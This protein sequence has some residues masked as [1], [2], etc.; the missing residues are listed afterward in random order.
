MHIGIDISVLRAAKGPLLR[1]HQNLIESLVSEGLVHE[2]TLVD[3]L[4]FNEGRAMPVRLRAFDEED[5]RVV[6]VTG[7][8][9]NTI[10]EYFG[11]SE[12]RRYDLANAVDR[13]LDEPWSSA[14]QANIDA[15]LRAVLDDVDVFHGSDLLW[16]KSP[17]G[18]AALTYFD[19]AHLALP[20]L[21]GDARPALIE[22]DAFAQHTAD[23]IIALSESTR[24]ALMTELKIPSER[25]SVVYGAAAAMFRPH[26]PEERAAA[27][28][29]YGLTDESYLLCSTVIEPRA[30][31]ERLAIAHQQLRANDAD[32]P[33][34]LIAGPRGYEHEAV[35]EAIEG[36]D[37]H[38]RVLD[39]LSDQELAA[40]LSGARG[41]V[42]PVFADGA[43]LIALEALACGAP[44]LVADVG[45]LPEIVG[46]AGLYC[47][48]K[49]AASISAGLAAL[50][51][52][53]RSGDLRVAGPKRA[54][55]YG[56][57]RSAAS[58]LTLYNQ[59][60]TRL[61]RGH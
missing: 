48:P 5:V 61:A 34:L 52:R 1:Y 50:L 28:A 36:Y 29:R 42:H 16:Y 31:L 39:D 49:S 45:A 21:V 55:Q 14:A 51:D 18:V 19:L 4:P 60:C 32:A 35:S 15:Q 43:G 47:D 3:V 33:P 6:R 44:L 20:A 11:L 41:V 9:R 46:D 27:L 13:S 7:L 59:L 30:N 22:K 24:Q 12:G 56:W 17:V 53:T 38:V 37:P 10:S 58:I 23:A 40:L 25:V 26:T 57:E 2:F 54:A 8:R